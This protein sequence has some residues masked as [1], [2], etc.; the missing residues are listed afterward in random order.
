MAELSRSRTRH[1]QTKFPICT[2]HSDEVLHRHCRLLPRISVCT[3]AGRPRRFRADFLQF[4][5]QQSTRQLPFLATR[6]RRHLSPKVPPAAQPSSSPP[7]AARSCPAK[8]APSSCGSLGS[9]KRD[10]NSSQKRSSR[11]LSPP[12]PS[13]ARL[14]IWS[15]RRAGQGMISPSL[16]CTSS[17]LISPSM[18]PRMATRMYV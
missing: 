7:S 2:P 16:L 14:R 8:S 5:G 1:T 6:G 4:K 10:F 13:S 15:L 12:G 18:G 9:V 17:S 3:V 11:A